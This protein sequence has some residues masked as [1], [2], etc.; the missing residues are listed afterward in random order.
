M[1]EVFNLLDG[2]LDLE[3][4]HPGFSWRA[5]RLGPR[6]GAQLLGA[7]VY[8]L[9]PGQRSFPYHFEHGAEEWLFV[10]SG[11][12]TLRTPEGER[13]L[14]PG[15]T[16]CFDAGPAGAHLLRNGT[17]EPARILLLSTKG[18]PGVA[19]YPDSDKIGIWTNGSHYMLRRQPQLGYWD[20]EG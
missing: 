1:A 15:E 7:T 14:D 3:R 16:I 20:G 5:A 2:E 17:D 12:P 6:L 10:V 19:E 18:D 13:D 9:E 11:R 8:E 4:D